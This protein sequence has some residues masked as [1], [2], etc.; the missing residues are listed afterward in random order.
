M[1]KDKKAV[2]SLK[3]GKV[4]VWQKSAPL[5]YQMIT[6]SVASITAYK[7]C[8]GKAIKTIES[9]PASECTHK[10]IIP[11]L[12]KLMKAEPHWPLNEKGKPIGDEKTLRNTAFGTHWNNMTNWIRNNYKADSKPNTDTAYDKLFKA[13][14]SFASN[15]S[16]AEFK[17][18]LELFTAVASKG[19]AYFE[20]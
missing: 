1:G 4:T 3:L 7:Y 11:A 13:L 2:N 14:K 10:D 16:D 5:T 17:Q 8:V 15:A 18:G 19:K 12:R 9:K 20:A 6:G